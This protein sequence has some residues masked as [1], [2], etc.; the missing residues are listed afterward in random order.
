MASVMTRSREADGVELATTA[1]VL[2]SS[3]EHAVDFSPASDV[4]VAEADG[5]LIGLARMWREERAGGV[6]AYGISVEV[7]PE[8]RGG[9]LREFLFDYNERRARALAA[10]DAKERSHVLL[11]WANDEENEWKALALR[12]G[13][14]PVQHEID[15]V[16]SLD[17]IPEVPLP[18]GIEVRPVTSQDVRVI[19]NANREAWR[20]AWNYSEAHWDDA[21]LE[22]FRHYPEFQPDLWQ[23]AW[24]GDVVVGTVLAYI[25][26]EENARYGRR[27]GH[28]ESVFVREGYRGRGIA[29]ALL[30]R[31]LRA[32]KERGMEEATLGTEVENPFG[33]LRLYEGMGFRIV[34]H[35]TWYQKFL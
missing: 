20:Q 2:A 12:R 9:G 26:P 15:L 17:D 24:D 21:H 23:V 35:F 25:L 16:R 27:R 14:A 3:F 30:A 18:A 28:T 8:R 11:L 34:K 22:A 31:S 13:Y 19:W 33:A 5:S 32:L 4:L 6:L 29:R 1:E 7:V 10:G